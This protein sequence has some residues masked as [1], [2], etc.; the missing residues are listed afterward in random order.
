MLQIQQIKD[1][2]LNEEELK[3]INCHQDLILHFKDSS[4]VILKKELSFLEKNSK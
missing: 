1:I 4:N 2:N 3:M